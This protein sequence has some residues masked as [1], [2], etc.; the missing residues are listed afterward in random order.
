MG[1][2]FGTGASLRRI[3]DFM[4]DANILARDPSQETYA[5][6]TPDRALFWYFPYIGE[7]ELSGPGGGCLS[8]LIGNSCRLFKDFHEHL[9]GQFSGLG[10]LI[11]GMVGGQ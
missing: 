2:P 4:R 11:G 10:V 7:G 8:L 5:A 9:A 3:L 1:H 6:A